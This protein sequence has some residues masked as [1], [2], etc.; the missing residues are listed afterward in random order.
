M[1]VLASPSADGHY[2]RLPALAADL[3]RRQVAVIVAI[4]ANSALAAKEA[5]ATIRSCSTF[6]DPV[7]L[8]LVANVAPPAGRLFQSWVAAFPQELGKL[9]WTEGRNIEITPQPKLVA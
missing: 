5:T 2:D 6:R 7:E 1:G 4:T 3:V 8:G 9:G